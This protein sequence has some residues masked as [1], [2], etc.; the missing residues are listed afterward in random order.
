MQIHLHLTISVPKKSFFFAVFG[1]SKVVGNS[2][3]RRILLITYHCRIA[4]QPHVSVRLNFVEAPLNFDLFFLLKSMTYVCS[5]LWQNLSLFS[6]RAQW[7]C[8]E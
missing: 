2:K 1:V 5:L 4:I 7:Y 3:R 6:L 8:A